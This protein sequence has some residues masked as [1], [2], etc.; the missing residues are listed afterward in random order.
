M[1]DGSGAEASLGGGAVGERPGPDSAATAIEPASR[2]VPGPRRVGAEASM[3]PRL[4]NLG[5]RN[6]V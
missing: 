4:A 5:D 3:A 1:T 2:T 6:R